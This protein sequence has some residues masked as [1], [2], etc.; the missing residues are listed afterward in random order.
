VDGSGHGG[1]AVTAI[2]ALVKVQPALLGGLGDRHGAVP[3]GRGGGRGG[4]RAGG[5]DDARHG[6]GAWTTYVE[7]LR[8]LGGQLTTPHNFAPGAVAHMAGASDAVATAIQ[9][10]SAA[11]AVAALLVA[12]RYASP[13]L[14]L[15]VTIVASQLVSSPLRDHYAVLLLLPT[16]WL[17]GAAGR[18]RCVPARGLDLTI[19]RRRLASGGQRPD[20]VLRLPGRAPLGGLPGTSRS[21]AGRRGER[22]AQRVK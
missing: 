10:V 3:R 18:G 19:R 9:L 17:V 21:R 15:Q 7:L 14:S 8:D 5:R 1:G 22:A 4:G 20:H 11:L 6:V 2:G 16:A 12:W 13:E